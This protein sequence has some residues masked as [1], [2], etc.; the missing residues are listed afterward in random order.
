VTRLAGY[1]ASPDVLDAFTHAPTMSFYLSLDRP[2]LYFVFSFV[3]VVGGIRRGRREQYAH[4]K[5]VELACQ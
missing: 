3:W 4:L 1:P 2:S 5:E